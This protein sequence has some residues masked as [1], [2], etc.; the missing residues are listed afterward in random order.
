[1]NILR[2]ANAA[3]SF[4]YNCDLRRLYPWPGVSDPLWGS[5]MASVRPDSATTPH[6]HDEE[7]TFLILSGAGRI[8]IDGKSS[9]VARGDVIYLP[10]HCRHF[11]TNVSA[12]APLEFLTIYWGSPEANARME[13]MV[14]ASEAGRSDRE[15][16]LAK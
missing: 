14:A 2:A 16:A 10:R 7:E 5:S 6:S 13:R 4:E 11:I 15:A 3:T 12:D 1:M 9:D 8:D